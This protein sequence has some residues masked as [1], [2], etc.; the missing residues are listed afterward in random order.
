MT[1]VVQAALLIKTE[2]QTAI[3]SLFPLYFG[4]ASL[5]CKHFSSWSQFSSL[6]NE[7]NYRKQ[8]ALCIVPQIFCLYV[9]GI[10]K[11]KI[12]TFAFTF[13][14]Q[15]VPQEY[16]S[17]CS[18][19]SCAVKTMLGENWIQFQFLVSQ[20]WIWNKGSSG[21]IAR[22]SFGRWPSFGCGVCACTRGLACASSSGK[23]PKGFAW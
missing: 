8:A 14:Q 7:R 22:V 13:E 2:R 19:L 10:L 17:S 21:F 4:I 15:M 3:Q 18:A 6:G 11:K 12:L 20:R 16:K 9:C 5:K 23:A 1:E